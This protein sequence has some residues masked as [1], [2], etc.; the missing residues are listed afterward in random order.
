MKAK[1]ES[2][3]CH[4]NTRGKRK[5]FFFYIATSEHGSMA[6]EIPFLC[7]EANKQKK[8]HPLILRIYLP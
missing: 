6:L 5:H 4:R 7:I 8:G 2:L 1:K 3:A